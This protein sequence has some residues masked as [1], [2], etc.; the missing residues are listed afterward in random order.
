MPVWRMWRPVAALRLK[1]TPAILL[2]NVHEQNGCSLKLLLLGLVVLVLRVVHAIA[3]CRCA[4]IE[5][6]W[7]RCTISIGSP[8]ATVIR[9]PNSLT[10]SR[11]AV[12][13]AP[14]DSMA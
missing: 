6:R 9:C 7:N 5:R 14:N 4:Q 12:F 10:N 3:L 8:V 13:T 11:P 2:Y 1:S